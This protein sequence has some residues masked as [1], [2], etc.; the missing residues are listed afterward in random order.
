MAKVALPPR[1]ANAA[2]RSID[3]SQSSRNLMCPC[4][5][6]RITL[7]HRILE[8]GIR[9]SDLSCYHSRPLQTRAHTHALALTPPIKENL[10]WH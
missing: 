4:A 10:P 5:C 2:H 6:S 8:T 1:A 7:N 9:G 3:P